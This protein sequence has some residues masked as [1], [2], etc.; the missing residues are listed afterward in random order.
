MKFSGVCPKCGG[1]HILLVEG[2]AGPYGVGNNI[3]VGMTIF[4]Y[5]MVDRYI[6]LRC[7]YSEE[8]I[9]GEDLGRLE[10]QYSK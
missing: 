1:E 8:W 9:P 4:S 6:C 5:A 7:G 3:P 2:K 10:K